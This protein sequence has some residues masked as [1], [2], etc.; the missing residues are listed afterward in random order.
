MPVDYFDQL[1]NQVEREV[2]A[3]IGCNDCLLACPL[4]EK[5]LVTIAELN[6]GVL[7]E[8]I[9]S[10]SVIAFVEACTQCQQCVAVCPADLHRADMV[11]WNK[12]KVED[13]APNRAMPLQTGESVTASQWTL[14]SL[15]THLSGIPLF[16]GVEPPLLR[17]MLLS[18]TLRQLAADEILCREG[19]YHERLYIVL[20]GQVEQSV[21][22]SAGRR[23]RILLMGSGSFHGE[24]SVLGNQEEP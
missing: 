23:T 21:A 8:S 12:M 1:H 20:D 16:G 6:D 3:C 18:S 10:P 15:S 19:E 5:Q 22:D 13:V 17:R 7:A 24:L 11:L 9:K 2:M 14:D 4:P